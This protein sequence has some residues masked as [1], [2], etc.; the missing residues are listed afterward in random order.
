MEITSISARNESDWCDIREQCYEFMCRYGNRRLTREG[1]SN[2]Q[3]LSFQQLNQPGTSLISATVRGEEG[4]I[5]VGI[6]FVAG[7]GE[8]ACLIAV[9]PLYRNKGI[10]T[11]LILSQQLKLGRLQCKVATDNYSSLKMCFQAGMHAVAIEN[12]PTGK[13]TLIMS[14]GSSL[15]ARALYDLDSDS[16]QEGESLCL[17]P[18]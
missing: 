1:C 11:S 3:K 18:F 9:H 2:L 8:T 13:A 7:F 12:G 17:N 4:R 15:L 5:P 6:C 14:G 16:T 10:G